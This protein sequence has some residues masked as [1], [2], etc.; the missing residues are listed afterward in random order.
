MPVL[1]SFVGSDVAASFDTPLSAVCASIVAHQRDQSQ[2]VTNLTHTHRYWNQVI[3]GS[4]SHLLRFA[5]YPADALCRVCDFVDQV[6]SPSMGDPPLPEG[7]GT[8]GPTFESYMCDGEEAGVARHLAT[9]SFVVTNPP[10][11]LTCRSYAHRNE[12]N[13]E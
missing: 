10:F 8:R 3:T 4:L 5:N 7:K 13:V 1:T 6:I 11:V 9:R 2:T 12:P